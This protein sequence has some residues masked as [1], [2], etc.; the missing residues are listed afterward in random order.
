MSLEDTRETRA[1]MIETA[2]A[3]E[4]RGLNQG[5]SGNVS[6]RVAG[7]M[8]ITPSGIPY[9]AMRPETIARMPLEGGPAEGPCK[10]SSEWHLHRA[11]YVARE[12]AEAVIHAHP[13]HA[14]ALAMART[15]IPACHYMVAAFGGDDVPLA[16]YAT[17]GSAALSDAVVAA[18]AGRTACLMANHGAT[19]IADGLDR[20]LWRLEEL[21]TLARGYILSMQAGGPHILGADEIEETLVKFD[22][23]GLRALP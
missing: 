23:Y 19:V 6:V 9:D 13:A 1:A 4:A 22:D 7:A 15:P 16:D 17:F 10:P 3:M 18:M 12:G 2:R 8:L 11:L 5:T 21:E 20:A 14:T